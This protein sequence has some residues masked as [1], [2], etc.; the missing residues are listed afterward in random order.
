MFEQKPAEEVLRELASC[1]TGLSESEAAE[2]LVRD[3][4]NV[5]QEKEP[6][7]TLQRFLSQLKDP[8][9]YILMAAA[10]VSVFLGEYS[11][12]II[13]ACV[14]L[15]NAVVGTLQEG[16]AQKALDA[17]KKMSSPTALVRREGVVKEVPAAQ[18]VKGDIVILDAGRVIP[19]D[20]R[21]TE[22]A[23]L[24][25]EE[26]ALTGE[27]VPVEKKAA[28]VAEGETPLGDR[29]NLA[30]MSTSVSYGRGEGVVVYT[31]QDTEIGKIATMINESEDEMTPL[32]LRLADLSKMLGILTLVICAAMFGLAIFQHRNIAEM[33]LTA[34]S[35]AVAAVPEGL[36][37][38]VTIVLA[39]G[40]QRM[41]KV[42]SIVRRL[43]A[44]ETLGAV[45]VVCSDKTGTLTQNKMTVTALYTNGKTFVPEQ[46]RYADDEQTRLMVNGFILC[47]DAS[48]AG[49]QRVGDPTELAFLDVGAPFGASRE[50][51]EET[52][53]R[54]NEQ[55]FDSDRKLMTTVHSENGRVVAYT[56]GATDQLLKRCTS[57]LVN[58]QARPITSEDHRAILAEAGKMA[59]DALRVLALAVKYEDETAAEQELCFVGMMGMIDPP[60]PEAKAAVENFKQAGV[61]TVMITGDHRDTAFAIAREL[62][63]ATDPDQCVTGEELDDMSQEEL[64]EQVKHLRV[65]A[66]VS[67]SHKVKIVSAFKANGKIVSMTGDGVNDAP[68]LKAAD[69]GV[70]M[71]ITG[72]DVAKS[73]ADMVLADDNFATIEKAIEEGRGIYANI[74]KTVVFLLSSNLGEVFSMFTAIAVGLASPLK[75]VHILWVNLITDSLPALALGSDE[76]PRGIMR[77]KPRDPKEGLFAGGAMTMTVGY[78]LLIAAITLGSFLILPIREV[79]AAGG[80]ISIAAIDAA[81]ENANLLLRAQ[82]Y[83]FSVLAVSQLFH[84]LGMRDINNSVFGA[85]AFRNKMM[86]VAFFGGLGLQVLATEV[87][88][89]SG[90][91][92]TANLHWS[93]WFML[94][95]IATVPLWVHEI[96]VLFKKMKY[97]ASAKN[98]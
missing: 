27:S 91:F 49:G 8:M 65:F 93:E 28:F 66:R 16:K 83:A 34:I 97:R 62:G 87:P 52:A 78:G 17:L 81:L 22:S 10:A 18:L 20:L 38:V 69:I 13:I 67:P 3:G 77:E 23:S 54:I 45:S 33:L 53:P 61:T 30:Y 73:A 36:P 72:T 82:T 92:D 85:H 11:D 44:V 19:A 76:K 6:P 32:Q 43:P 42:N 35:L 90:A 29:I 95:A 9:I 40:V 24:K 96:V 60:R 70:A 51:L 39:I 31:G 26:S 12:A 68:S 80:S 86:I 94:I 2:R 58:G 15:L 71:G 57:I 64:N 79:L 37:A 46:I 63:I 89:F 7:T 47:T 48:L 98:Q 25:I 21:L 4:E 56:K 55:A 74:K 59:N 88:F 5:L 84:S 50:G 14:V 41:V 75:A 1:K